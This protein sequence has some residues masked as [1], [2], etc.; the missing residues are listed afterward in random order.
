MKGDV[1][2]REM[3]IGDFKAVAALWRDAE[4]LSLTED[5]E[6][7]GMALY[8]KRNRGLCFVADTGKD[9][10]G[11]V[12]CGHDGRRGILRH[13]VV[14][15]DYRRQGIGRSLVAA[16]LQALEVDG[17]RKCNIFVMDSNLGGMRYWKNLGFHQLADEY[18]TL[19]TPVSAFARDRSDKK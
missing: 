10:V 5:D 2:I 7:P 18:R 4:G 16:A 13:L 3:A 6:E 17:I 15:R 9:L 19:Q 8:L 11:T 14:R 12:L 1:V